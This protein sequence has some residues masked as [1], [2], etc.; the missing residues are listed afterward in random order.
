MAP[1]EDAAAL[2]RALQ[3]AEALYALLPEDMAAREPATQRKRM[4]AALASAVRAN[5]VA[6]VVLLS[7]DAAALAAG[8]G[9][10]RELHL[11]ES[12]LRAAAATLSVLR[13]CYFQENVLAALGAAIRD[14]VYPNFLPS[15]DLELPMV[16][17]RDV[18]EVAVSCLLEEVKR[19]ELI[20]VVG[21]LY[22]ARRAAQLLGAAL[23]KQLHVVDVPAEEQL[24]AFVHGGMSGEFAAALVELYT[25]I[26]A[27]KVRREGDRSV[28]GATT[29]EQTLASALA[30]LARADG[31]STADER[32]SAVGSGEGRMAK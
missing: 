9:P 5:A 10:A 15:A 20:D 24:A 16:A 31:G 30:Q 22:S 7:A 29:L 8:N 11:A 18:A 27:G 19:S 6:H 25:C 32:R 12:E 26:A 13:A 2:E 4:V 28:A 14:G 17:T 1:L 23:G 3:G 21:P